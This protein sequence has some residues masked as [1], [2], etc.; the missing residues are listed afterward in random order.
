MWQV[1]NEIFSVPLWNKYTVQTYDQRGIRQTCVTVADV[2][3]L[4]YS[5]KIPW[6]FYLEIWINLD[7]QICIERSKNKGEVFQPLL[8][9]SESPQAAQS[10]DEKCGWLLCPVDH[11]S[12]IRR[13]T[14]SSL[15]YWRLSWSW[16][17][18][19]V[20]VFLPFPTLPEPHNP[21]TGVQ[22]RADPLWKQG[23]LLIQVKSN[24]KAK[25]GKKFSKGPVV[26]PLIFEGR[27]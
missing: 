9:Y 22:A 1:L 4:F 5:R 18:R 16:R 25:F 20:L 6:L 17:L 13:R 23:P 8:K 27:K 26:S 2:N 12:R 19:V 7:I 3:R 14:G 24:F 15:L 21:L 11:L 10:Q